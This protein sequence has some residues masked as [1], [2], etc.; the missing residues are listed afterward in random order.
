MD[1]M[2]EGSQYH[3]SAF[4]ATCSYR[5]MTLDY[6]QHPTV[7][8]KIAKKSIVGNTNRVNRTEDFVL[9]KQASNLPRRMHVHIPVKWN[10]VTREF[11]VRFKEVKLATL[12][13]YS[14][15]V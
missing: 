5:L 7:V 14:A 8:L 9:V 11:H 1:R 3:L 13:I 15:V 4:A 2:A 10:G 6:K 12:H